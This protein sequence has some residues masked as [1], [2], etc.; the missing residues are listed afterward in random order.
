MGKTKDLGHLAHIVAYN[1]ENH[2][3]VPAGI[4]MHT[5]QLVASQAWVT[6]A[7]GSY[8]LSSSLSSYVPTSRTITIN[9]TT[10]DL[11]ANRNWDIT[12]MIYPA[13]GIA[14]S[15]GS[16][17]GT[18]ITNNSAN[19]NT[20]FGWGNH[21]SAGY[22]TGITSLLV[23]NALGFTPYNSTNPAGYVTASTVLN[24]VLTPYAVGANTA[25]TTTDTIETA[26]EKLQGQVNARVPSARTLTINGTAFDLSA[27]RSWTISA[28]TTLNG[29]GFVK[30]SGTTITYDNST[31]LTGITS[32]L[33]TGA[34]GYT[35]YN[36][37]NPAGYITGISF[38]NV[39]SKPT[40]LSGYGITDAV[41]SARTITINGTAFDLSA[42]RS[43]TITLTEA[44]TLATVTGRG[45]S[46]STSITAE[47]FRG[48]N[49]LVLNTYT[50]VNPSSNVFLY[51]QPNDR[52]SWIYLD[53]ADTG[54]N[55]GIY[56]RQI[57]SAV[58]GL[59][60]NSIGFIG[61]GSSGL[62]AFIGLSTGNGYFAGTISASNYSGTH[63]GSSS[64]TNTGDQTNISGN[65]G[66]VGSRSVGNS[67]GNIAYYDANGNLYVNNPESYSGEVRLGAAW[68]RGGVYTSG[69]LS[70]STSSSNIHFVFGNS[71]PIS[72]TSSG[73]I[74]L[75]GGANEPISITGAAHKYLTIN[76]GNGYEA[77]VRYIGGS[78]SSWYVGKRTSGQ[79][80]GT[81][82][83]HFYSEEAGAT[84]GG[85][86]P[87]GVMFSVGA[88][89]APIF[90]DHN[91][92]GY[93]LDPNSESSL[94][95]FTS[96]TMTRNAMNYLSI[97]S[98]FTTRAAQAGPYQN[99]TMGWGT[100]DFNTVFSNW[101]SGFI[102]T[103]SNPGNAPGGSSHYIGLQSCHY[104]HQNSANVYGFQ[105][106]CAGEASNRYFWR[107][108][109]PGMQSWVEMV[110]SGN[111]GSQTVS[112]ANNL[113]GFDKTNPS[114]G[115]VYASNW[116][117]AQ[118][119]CGLYSQDYGGHMR[120]T[121]ASSYGNWETF[122]YEKSGWSGFSYNYNYILN[123]MSNTSG[124]HGFY[125]QNGNG[126][127]LFYN[128][129]N[130]CW[131][132][133]TDNTYSGDG[134][135]CVKYGSAEYGFTTWSDRRA[136]ENIT[137]ITGALNKVLGMNGMYYNYIKD[138][139]KSQHV[140]FIAQDLLEILPQSVRYAEDIDEYNINYGP[141]VSV[142][143]EA[144]K[145][146]N[147]KITRLETLVEQLTNN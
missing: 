114:F 129:G 55:W 72:M 45:A 70:L 44:D 128:R 32:A 108:A 2:I 63:S 31:Y 43:W 104:N 95:R 28:G 139:T 107:N 1:A 121:I 116:F 93:Y 90:Y 41:P 80:V 136:K 146:Q 8:A 132:I 96:T 42:N 99:G 117:R 91:D 76:P 33:V 73:N 21:A 113:S 7:L 131:G 87:G 112:T 34:L 38:A 98:P 35:P 39:S 130:N 18:S 52:D 77:M 143:A 145:E 144:I 133:G 118:G 27:D 92:T 19:W 36:A 23:T 59:E 83:F 147:A 127:T 13:A 22:L 81:Q 88:M 10:F 11:S 89:R 57:D 47:R 30:A 101:G 102:D 78:G 14:L 94:Y 122:G 46:T 79:L 26:I 75:S 74:S 60:A 62:K 138:E 40:T 15:T 115:A 61:G 134:F 25:V 109:W 37:T 16:A 65:A 137:P 54:S 97:N 51:S 135:R 82:S 84:V 86:D 58:S 123:L 119:D 124:D 4:T 105:M 140:G 67:A 3:T 66:T 126:W 111:I 64:G 24:A 20:A 6:T 50:T 110:H 71:V 12:S 56:H 142:L 69:T 68:G 85:I 53:S 17:W 29:T 103:W 100:T 5:N 9:G 106:A 125:Q 48:N 141:I 120:R 49:T